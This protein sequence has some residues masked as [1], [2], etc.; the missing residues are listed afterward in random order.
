MLD[1][2]YDGSE[3]VAMLSG[4]TEAVT[5]WRRPM[6]TFRAYMVREV[7]KQIEQ[8]GSASGGTARGV[9]WDGYA[10]QYTRR[11]GS[12][13]PAWGGVAKVRGKGTVQGKRNGSGRIISKGSR[14]LAN[15]K[16]GSLLTV[17]HRDNNSISIG[18]TSG[19]AARMN[20]M[21]QFAFY[22]EPRDVEKLERI[23]IAYM[24]ARAAAKMKGAH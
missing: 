11:D 7:G 23:A 1:L 5:D 19:F 20:T 9:R 22:Q 10:P 6:N 16:P 14:M 17:H 24:K 21:R 13:V 4:L 12:T 8:A 18:P 3:A 15:V 2:E